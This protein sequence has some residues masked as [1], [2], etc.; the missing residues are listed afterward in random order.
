LGVTGE[1]REQVLFLV[2]EHLLLSDTATRRNLGDEDL[3]LH[4]AAR[5]VD[6]ERLGMLYLL[7]MADALATGPTAA[8]PWRLGLIR[9]LVAKV[10]RAFERGQMDPDRAGRLER[11]EAAIRGVL[12]GRPAEQVE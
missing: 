8:T 7:T 2:R 10:S 12:A 4:V 6:Q 9:E 5:V 1:R 3:I 11:A